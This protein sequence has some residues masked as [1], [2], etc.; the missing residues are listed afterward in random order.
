MSKAESFL[1]GPGSL[2]KKGERALGGPGTWKVL[3]PLSPLRRPLGWEGRPA[4]RKLEP[5]S[6]F[7]RRGPWTPHTPHT[8]PGSAPNKNLEGWV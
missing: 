4:V 3:G 6:G 8:L 1:K 7:A 2:C 5:L